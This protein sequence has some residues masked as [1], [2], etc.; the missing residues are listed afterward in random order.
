MPKINH[1]VEVFVNPENLFDKVTDF[2]NIPNVLGNVKSVKIVSNENNIVVTE[3]E[4]LLMGNHSIQQVRHTLER[5]Y[6]HLAEVLSG[7]AEGSVIEQVFEKTDN[8][9]K[10]TINADFK[11]KGKLKLIGFAIKNRVK[12][13]LESAIYEFADSIDESNS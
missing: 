4:V 12:F 5:P 2:V 7:E 3:D 9:T 11:L 10:V 1:V 8:G 6:R 13:G